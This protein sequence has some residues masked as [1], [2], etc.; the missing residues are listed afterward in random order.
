MGEVTTTHVKAALCVSCGS[1]NDVFSGDGV[2]R[3]G[4]LAICFECGYVT[5]IG[6]GKQLIELPA[7]IKEEVL[8]D[9]IV[10]EIQQ[11]VYARQASLREQVEQNGDAA[12]FKAN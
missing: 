12:P 7:E 4:E 10:K 9:P 5:L 6:P 8:S 1:V 2:P 3:E 11:L